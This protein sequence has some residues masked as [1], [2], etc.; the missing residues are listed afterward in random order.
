MMLGQAAGALDTRCRFLDPK[1]DSPAARVG[2]LIAAPY[3]NEDGLARLI[4]GA[5]VATYE[6][7]NVPAKAA[8]WLSERMLTRPPAAAL[9]AAQ[10]RL[11]E[12]R[13]FERLGARVGPYQAVGSVDELHAAISAIGAPAILK[14]RRLGY[15]G[16]GQCVLDSFERAEAAW[17]IVGRSPSILEGFIKFDREVSLI[18]VRSASGSMRFYPLVQNRHEAGILR[19]STAPAPFSDP[20]A[21]NSLQSQAEAVGRAALEHFEY[22]GALTIEFFQCGDLLLVNEMAPRVHNSG[23]WTIEG[24]ATSQFE[25]HLRAVLD[26]P[27]GECSMKGAAGMLNI[28]GEPPRDLAAL[29][30]AGAHVHLY[31]KSPRPGRK[32]GHMTLV[33]DSQGELRQRIEQIKRSGALDA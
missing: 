10:D 31:G 22:I 5:S 32:L 7:E 24:A 29:E 3:D 2:D 20:D 1:P 4:Q 21:A 27:L 18:C 19:E 6:F 23:H 33:A 14:S 12:K 30:A 11:S 25:N 16:R 26:L 17:E 9:A 15:D 28:I 8:A 13:L